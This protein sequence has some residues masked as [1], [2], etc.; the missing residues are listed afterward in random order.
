ML[1]CDWASSS[2]TSDTRILTPDL[3]MNLLWI[4]SMMSIGNSMYRLFIFI[5]LNRITF[6][7]LNEEI[8]LSVITRW[9][10]TSMDI[11]TVLF[12]VWQCN[13]LFLSF[14]DF[15]IWLQTLKLL[16]CWLA[17]AILEVGII[18]WLSSLWLY[19]RR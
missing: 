13:S 16:G 11:F 10:Y 17:V 5:I 18:N 3:I 8:R 9:F 4:N 12:L 19:I 15:T 6:P 1:N 14:S 2:T 7:I